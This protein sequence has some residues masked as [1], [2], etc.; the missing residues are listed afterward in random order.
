MAD[1]RILANSLGGADEVANAKE[2]HI[3]LSRSSTFT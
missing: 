3:R 1:M 2:H